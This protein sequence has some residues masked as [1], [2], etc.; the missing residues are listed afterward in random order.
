MPNKRQAIN[1]TI[2]DQDLWCHKTSP[3]PQRV[4]Q[5]SCY[6]YKKVEYYLISSFSYPI[7]LFLC[8]LRIKGIQWFYFVLSILLG[9]FWYRATGSL[10]TWMALWS[11]SNSSIKMRIL[12]VYQFTWPRKMF[13]IWL[14]FQLYSISLCKILQLC[15]GKVFVCRF[16]SF[17]KCPK[18][19][20]IKMDQLKSQH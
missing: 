20:F 14:Y 13:I 2:D 3:E 1:L 17:E 18:A 5:L 6:C 19:P 8:I 10:T 4:T 12:A 16:L 7:V 9:I 11:C 15:Q